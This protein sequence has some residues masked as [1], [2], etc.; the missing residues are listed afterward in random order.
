M[1]VLSNS[2]ILSSS[3][4]AS[5]LEVRSQVDRLNRSEPSGN[6]KR[7]IVP[8]GSTDVGR[9]AT[10]VLVAFENLPLSVPH[11]IRPAVAHSSGRFNHPARL[12]LVLL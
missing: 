11:N 2:I 9:E 5:T 3:R 6:F 8:Y 12:Y 10:I 4:R 1:G 7:V